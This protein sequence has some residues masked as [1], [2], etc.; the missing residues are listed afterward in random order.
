M[1]SQYE[2]TSEQN[3][4]IGGL[5]SKMRFVGMFAVVLGVVNLLIALLVV[6][7]VY[8]DR[9]PATWKAKTKDYL[10]KAREKL[11]DDVK[12]QAEEYSLEK[13][14][15]NHHLWGIAVNLGVVGLFYLLMGVWTRSAG[16]SFL[17]IVT[18]QSNDITHLMNGLRSLHSMYSLLYTLLMVTLLFG[19]FSIILTLYQYFMAH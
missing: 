3:T 14:P 2:F 11:P 1:S 17:K 9:V 4:L 7:A 19:L 16:A 13:L 15:A 8:Q 12:K 5:G 18:T 10:E 6:L